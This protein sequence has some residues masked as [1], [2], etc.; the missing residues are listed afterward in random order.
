MELDAF[1]FIFRR[2][3]QEKQT[4]TTNSS[5]N[6]AYTCYFRAL[7]RRMAVLFPVITLVLFCAYAC[8]KCCLVHLFFVSIKVFSVYLFNDLQKA[9]ISP[10]QRIFISE[11]C[12]LFLSGAHGVGRRH[13]KNTLINKYPERFSYP[14]PRK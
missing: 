8:P 12:R 1:W 14:V 6:Q 3:T 2:T 10:R 9:W 4:I 11:L 5:G 7:A 13:I